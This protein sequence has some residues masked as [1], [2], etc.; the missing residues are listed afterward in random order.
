MRT[1]AEDWL[2]SRDPGLRATRRA[3]RTAIVMP[4]LFA[5]GTEVVGDATVAT[6]AAFGSFALLLFADFGGSLADRLAA[7]LTLTAL[8]G[9]FVCTATV[10]SRSAWSAATAM[11]VVGFGVLFAGVVSS[12]LA[13]ASTSALLAFVL[14]V[15]TPG[16]L[17]TLP[18]RLAGWLLAGAVSLPAVTLLWPAPATDPLRDAAAEACRR[19]SAR[20]T[21]EPATGREAGSTAA[22]A[23]RDADEAVAALRRVFLATP[24]RPSGLG[25]A[26]R[27]V[28]RLVDEVQWLAGVLDDA[29]APVPAGPAHP[30]VARVGSAAAVLLDHAGTVLGA[31]DQPQDSLQDHLDDLARARRDMES[32]AIHE[33]ARRAGGAAGLPAALEPAFRAQELARAV[34]AIGAGV[35]VAAAADQRSWWRRLLGGRPAGLPGPLL[36]ARQRALAH[37]EPHSVW[38]HNSVRG[39]IGL[40]LAVLVADLS[41][42]QHSFW[43]VLGA[44]SV[45]RSNA[46]STGQSA[47]RGLLG[48]VAG[49]VLGGLLV[50]AVGASLPVLWALLPL[51]VLVAG[52]APA[53]SFAAGQA[54]FTVT[55]LVLFNV[56][57]PAG[58]QVGLVRVEDV[59]LGCACSLLVGG[60]FWPRGAGAALARA[61][62]EAYADAA[63]ALRSATEQDHDGRPSGGPALRSAASARRLDDAFREFLAERGPKRLSLAEVAALLNGVAGL[64]LTADAVRSLWRDAGAARH[65]R[66][67]PRAAAEVVAATERVT[68]WYASLAQAFA[69]PGVVPRALPP[70]PGADGRLVE[71][72]TADLAAHGALAGGGGAG[73]GAPGGGG[74]GGRRVGAAPPDTPPP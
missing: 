3:V 11:L 54:G 66:A 49:F 23:A 39:A 42:A 47:L 8:G 21:A 4:A 50:V 55:L 25:T 46:L 60:L 20:L 27:A 18:D 71:A 22:A 51:A 74:R 5:L 32:A 40:A 35:A 43:L 68:N 61:L 45:L 24:Y 44:L 48:T 70:D 67:A 34:T 28:V 38:L 69:G 15:T 30:A 16:G 73:R 58:W 7:Q 53:V 56:I 36:S 33:V 41:G 6:F 59:A 52:I 13:G 1:A 10:A 64:R 65:P 57:G 14:P 26:A 31:R 37:L 17:D 2:R 62:A 29:A 9:V 63:A 72:L 12:A 19:L